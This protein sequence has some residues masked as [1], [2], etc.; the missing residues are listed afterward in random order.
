MK[1]TFDDTIGREVI[2]EITDT[3]I[4]FFFAEN[5]RKQA[6]WVERQEEMGYE[7]S[8]EDKKI[9]EF[10]WIEKSQWVKDKTRNT[11]RDDNWHNHMNGKNWFTDEM[12]NFIN[13][14]TDLL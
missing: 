13:K 5:V 4:L 6:D 12:Y 2:V 1:K 8:E 11:E 3:H 9:N 10:Y 14:N 7:V